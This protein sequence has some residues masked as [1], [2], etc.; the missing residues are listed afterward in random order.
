[1]RLDAGREEEDG[2]ARA[3]V[4]GNIF[5][6]TALGFSFK[7]RTFGHGVMGTHGSYFFP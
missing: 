1:M 3:W 4:L 7:R 5:N 2:K 6:D